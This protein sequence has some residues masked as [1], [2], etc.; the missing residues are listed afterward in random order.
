MVRHSGY[1][2]NLKQGDGV[3]ADKGFDVA[4]EIGLMGATL[5]TP[6]FKTSDQLTQKETEVSRGV[7]NVRIHIEC[8]IGSI[9]MR[10][11]IMCGPVVMSNLYNFEKSICLYDKIGAVCCIINNLNPSI[12]PFG[13]HCITEFLSF[14]RFFQYTQLIFLNGFLTTDFFAAFLHVSHFQFSPNLFF[15]NLTRQ[16]P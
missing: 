13:L 14:S 12:V 9:R 11:D 5:T 1:K 15:P 3:L 4:E 10:F 8:E 16:H 6:A 7:S 2:E